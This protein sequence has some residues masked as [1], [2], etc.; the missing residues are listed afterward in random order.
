MRSTLFSPVEYIHGYPGAD[1]GGVGK[2]KR[3][4]KNGAMK[5]EERDIFSRPFYIHSF[6]PTIC[7]WVSGGLNNMLCMSVTSRVYRVVLLNREVLGKRL[8]GCS[9]ITLITTDHA[10]QKRWRSGEHYISFLKSEIGMKP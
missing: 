6:A 2:Y 8:F 5:S 4:E 10:E 1:S 3:A 7:P 9:L